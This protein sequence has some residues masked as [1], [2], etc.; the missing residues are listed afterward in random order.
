MR[1]TDPTPSKSQVH[2]TAIHK[3]VF[4]P[5][6]KVVSSYQ[7]LIKSVLLGARYTQQINMFSLYV[8]AMRI[9]ISVSAQP[10]N[11][12]TPAHTQSI[13]QSLPSFQHKFVYSVSLVQV[14]LM[15]T[16]ILAISD[17]FRSPIHME[18]YLGLG[19]YIWYVHKLPN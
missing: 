5:L 10:C 19:V 2:I 9:I 6:F 12:I 14:I 17:C 18:I 1:K 3:G 16:G 7:S 4:A 8:L 13:A 15:R 11:P